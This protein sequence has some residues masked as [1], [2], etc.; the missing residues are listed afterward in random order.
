MEVA[1]ATPHKR[2]GTPT[3]IAEMLDLSSALAT[4]I[5]EQNDVIFGLQDRTI[6]FFA[7]TWGLVETLT[8]NSLL[9]RRDAEALLSTLREAQRHVVQAATSGQQPGESGGTWVDA[10]PARAPLQSGGVS[11]HTA[12]HSRQDYARIYALNR[13]YE[14]TVKH[15]AKTMEEAVQHQGRLGDLRTQIM[16]AANEV[17]TT[18]LSMLALAPID[19]LKAIGH[20]Q[21]KGPETV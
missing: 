19:M 17:L 16:V 9:S 2:E 12:S 5:Q 7:K 13:L 10:V 3:V 21:E 14:D 20:P 18:V 4:C 8:H 15:L 6:D 1:H 11:Y